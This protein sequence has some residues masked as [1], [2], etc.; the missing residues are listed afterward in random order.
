METNGQIMI[1]HPPARKRDESSPR[2]NNRLDIT[3][4]HDGKGDLKQDVPV[5]EHDGR[6]DSK[7][8]LIV[9][10]DSKNPSQRHIE[11][12]RQFHEQR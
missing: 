8:K 3:N 7:D 10:Q 1:P 5:E 4:V 2:R 6:R 11:G 12:I 9:D